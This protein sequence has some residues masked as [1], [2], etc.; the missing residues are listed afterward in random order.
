MSDTPTPGQA[1]APRRYGV[2][3]QKVPPFARYKGT[4]AWRKNRL[5]VRAYA[6][7]LAAEKLKNQQSGTPNR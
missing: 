6:W 7:F 1:E 2:P 3:R 4:S 5:R